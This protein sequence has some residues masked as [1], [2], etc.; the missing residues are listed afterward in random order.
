MPP[1]AMGSGELALLADETVEDTRGLLGKV[2]S[3]LREMVSLLEVVLWG[4][5]TW[6]YDRQLASSYG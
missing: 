6:N 5:D 4:C 1:P 2:T 3:L